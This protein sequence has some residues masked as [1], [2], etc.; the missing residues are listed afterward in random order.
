VSAE[1]WKHASIPFVAGL[2]GWGTNW[3]AIRLTFLPLKFVGLRPYLG[4]QGIIPSKAA[5]MARIF[6]EKTM[7]RLGTL[8]ELFQSMEPETI[9]AHVSELLDGR[10]ES[11]TDEVMFYGS[12]GV[13]KMTPRAIK[14]SVYARVRERMP[15]LLDGLVREI[16]EKIEELVDFKEMLVDTL[17]ADRNLLNRL[18]LES[19]A[20]EFR[21]IVRS[22]LYFGFLFGLVQLTVWSLWKSWWVLPFFGLLVGAVTNWVAISIIF[23]PLHPRRVGPWTLQGLFLKR[24]QEVS[25]IWSRL[26]TSE[27][28]T[29]QRIVYTMIYGSRAEQAHAMIRRHIQPIVD[30]ITQSMAPLADIAVGRESLDGIRRNVGDK[31]VEVSTE[32]FDH[33]PFNRERGQLAEKMLGQRMAELPPSEFQDLLR[34]CFQE[35][36]IKLIVL[37]GVLGL[38]AGIAQLFLVFGGGE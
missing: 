28:V 12:P 5:K 24:Q 8:Q 2:V 37:G 22:G 27:I 23:R 26:V 32:P 16:T 17:E 3:V 18:F 13:W 36:E 11:Y 6:V 33:W 9:T 1:F 7:F 35:D 25:A 21:F 38:L 4:W 15:Q 29:L 19:G 20:A 31:A 10:L 14:E 34:P 30:E